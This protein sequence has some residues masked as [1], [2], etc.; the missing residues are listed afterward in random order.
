MSQYKATT[1]REAEQLDFR[2]RRI[3]L[4]S[5]TRRGDRVWVLNGNLRIGIGIPRVNRQCFTLPPMLVV[6]VGSTEFAAVRNMQRHEPRIYDG[7]L[8]GPYAKVTHS[9]SSIFLAL[10]YDMI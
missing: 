8:A 9:W 6:V 1:A 4:W 2:P 3:G 7:Y 5:D 10:G